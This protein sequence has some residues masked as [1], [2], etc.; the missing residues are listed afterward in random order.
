MIRLP[1][2]NESSKLNKDDQI[3]SLDQLV[4]SLRESYNISPSKL[5]EMRSG[6]ENVLSDY[7]NEFLSNNSSSAD[8]VLRLDESVG[9]GRILEGIR[10]NNTVVLYD[11]QNPL[12]EFTNNPD[13]IQYRFLGIEVDSVPANLLIESW[14]CQDAK[15]LSPLITY[16]LA[17]KES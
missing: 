10:L 8:E 2:V 14:N 15:E 16:I 4:E 5:E 3:H 13:G 7:L 12:V 1:Q 6:M 9:L 17:R 11:C